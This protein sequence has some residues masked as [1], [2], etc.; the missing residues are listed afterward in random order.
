MHIGPTPSARLRGDFAGATAP[1]PALTAAVG[2][3]DPTAESASFAA[4]QAASAVEDAD[5]PETAEAKAG[6]LE[7]AFHQFVGQTLFGSMLKSMRS[8]VGKP[9][10]FHGGQTEEIF[11]SQLDEAL[12]EELTKSSADKFAGPMFELFQ[13]Q[14][15]Q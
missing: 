7:E 3:P 11:Q 15:H 12:T 9:A 14:R 4:I 8:T 2:H 5:S 6:E 10:Y 1:S 13:L